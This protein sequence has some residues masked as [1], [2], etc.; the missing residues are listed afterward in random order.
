MLSMT[1]K[2]ELRLAELELKE[3]RSLATKAERALKK[4]THL[5]EEAQAALT[6]CDTTYHQALTRYNELGRTGSE[7]TV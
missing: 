4:A 2:Q 5:S 6:A 3:A 7:S 1:L